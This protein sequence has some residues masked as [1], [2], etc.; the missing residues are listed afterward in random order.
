MEPARRKRV[1]ERAEA[2]LRGLLRRGASASQI[3]QAAERVR[4]AYLGLVKGQRV[5]ATGPK[6]RDDSVDRHLANLARAIEIWEALFVEAIVARYAPSR[7]E[8][9][10]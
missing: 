7:R 3:A 6:R 2:R 5:I 4:E 1:L 8:G 9:T 10:S